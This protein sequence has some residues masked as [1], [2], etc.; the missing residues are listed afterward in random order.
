[1]TAFGIIASLPYAVNVAAY[2]I[3]W[4]KPFVANAI[5]LYDAVMPVL[6]I[7]EV[8]SLLTRFPLNPDRIPGY[9][10]LRNLAIGLLNG[11]LNAFVAVFVLYCGALAGCDVVAKLW[12]ALY[13]AADYRVAELTGYLA[14]FAAAT[15]TLILATIA[16]WRSLE[17]AGRR[18]VVIDNLA[19]LGRLFV[20]GSVGLM[21]VVLSLVMPRI[22]YSLSE[23]LQLLP[24]PAWSIS[25]A[26]PQGVLRLSGE[27]QYGVS[28]ALAS[29]LAHDP[30]IHRLELDSPGGDAGQGLALAALIEKYSLSTFVRRE[31]LSA[32]VLVFAAG[33]E[34]LLMAGAKLG[35]H[36]AQSHV[37]DDIIDNDGQFNQEYTTFLISKGVQETF[38]RKA[39]SVPYDDM[40]YPSVDE[41][42]AASAITSK[43][44]AN[45]V[46][47]TTKPSFDNDPAN[48]RADTS[49]T[50]LKL[51]P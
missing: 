19:T 4:H 29:A 36:R 33:H 47:Q 50:A 35:Y 21:L 48:L 8:S 3:R 49:N 12:V 24:G 31:C 10:R 30:T 39:Y 27:L 45:V 34:R 26:G 2:S 23:A 17:R 6:V 41:L 22:G 42:L 32:C 38:A 7:A 44:L 46:T 20:V 15:F 25:R 1:V 9:R 16:T 13:Q 51:Q 5:H 40:W 14:V 18:H 43:P 37:W 28:D 11:K